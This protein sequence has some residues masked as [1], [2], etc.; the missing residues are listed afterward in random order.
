MKYLF[1]I[2]CLVLCSCEVS[3]PDG[4]CTPSKQSKE[5]LFFN[6]Q[7]GVDSIIVDNAFWWF[8]DDYTMECESIIRAEYDYICY[9]D[10]NC[11]NGIR[12]ENDYC[13]DNYCENTKGIIFTSPYG[14]PIMKIE[15]SWFSVTKTDKSTLFVSV[16]QNET[17]EK[18]EQQIYIE[19]G[20]CPSVFSIIQS[21]E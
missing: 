8:P 20:D 18:R 13:K 10:D 15:C 2:F 16:N 19:D 21:A 12:I 3:A 7:G 17:R 6:V 14:V 9:D 5:N 4:S 1:L 11:K